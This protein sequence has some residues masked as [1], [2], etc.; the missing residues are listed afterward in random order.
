[1]G[2]RGDTAAG[3]VSAVGA[4]SGAVTVNTPP[5]RTDAAGVVTVSGPVAAPTGT[6]AT[7][8]V[9]VLEV[10]YGGDAVE[11]DLVVAGA[12]AEA[13]AGDGHGRADAPGRRREARDG[14]TARCRPLNAD[15]VSRRIVAIAGA[16]TRGIDDAGE[17]PDV[18]VDVDHVGGR[19]RPERRC[20]DQREE[21]VTSSASSHRIDLVHPIDLVLIAASSAPGAIPGA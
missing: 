18:V 9:A 1:M 15:Q 14:G 19:G 8:R 13:R 3:A 4:R 11:R 5:L 20:E 17:A 2:C 7:S 12:R 10:T 21:G 16:V 6:V